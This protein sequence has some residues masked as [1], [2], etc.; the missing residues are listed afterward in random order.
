MKS[1]FWRRTRQ[2]KVPRSS[3][4]TPSTNRDHS[5][6][7]VRDTGRKR[8]PSNQGAQ[9]SHNVGQLRRNRDFDFATTP[10]PALHH[11]SA[12]CVLDTTSQPRGRPASRCSSYLGWNVRPAQTDTG[13]AGIG[14][15]GESVSKE[16]Q[17]KMYLLK[18]LN[19][20]CNSARF[21]LVIP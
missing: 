10:Q 21:Y 19:S 12:P 14:L 4:S 11:T 1:G 8:M 5:S 3:V 6:L 17:K 13:G 16:L 9:T 15:Q 7:C 18:N 2:D 20:M